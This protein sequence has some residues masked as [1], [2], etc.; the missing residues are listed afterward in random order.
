MKYD[1]TTKSVVLEMIP[2][3][4]CDQTGQRPEHKRC[5]N[6]NKAMRGKPCEYCGCTTKHNHQSIKTGNMEKCWSCKGAGE[7]LEWDQKHMTWEVFEPW[8][9]DATIL[10]DVSGGHRQTFNEA[11]LGIG[12][13]YCCTD[14]G[15]C[16][17]AL[18]EAFKDRGS[19]TLQPELRVFMYEWFKKDRETP[20]TVTAV[21]DFS[22][23]V[24][25]MGINVYPRRK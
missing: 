16:F 9:K 23:R 19:E 18:V 25:P 17:K 8:W 20:F 1:H 6:S 22:I 15:R 11:Y 7:H 3:T 2:C 4:S 13:L 12:M 10:V 14:Y 5:P 21:N 24:H